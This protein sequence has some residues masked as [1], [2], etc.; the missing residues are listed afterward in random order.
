MNIEKLYGLYG[1]SMYRYLSVKLGSALDAEDVLQ[2]VLCRLVR[3]PLKIRLVRN[4][5]AYVFRMARN[6]ANR[7]LRSRL[8]AGHEAGSISE[9]A[10]AIEQTISGPDEGSTRHISEALAKIPAEQ[11]EVIVLK[12]FEGLTFREIAGMRGESQNTV[13]SRYR[14]GLEKL[15]QVMENRA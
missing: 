3:Y 1:E 8:R 12:V 9:I 11:R 14:Y 15:R 4:P 7:F 5:R 10:A 13:A 2:Q 6:E